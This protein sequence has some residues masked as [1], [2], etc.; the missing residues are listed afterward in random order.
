MNTGVK[1]D[2]TIKRKIAGITSGGNFY[3]LENN[4]R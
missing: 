3:I 2:V 1:G 4:T